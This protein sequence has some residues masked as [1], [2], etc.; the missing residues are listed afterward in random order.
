MKIKKI[1]DLSQQIHEQTQVYPGDPQ[2]DFQPIATIERDGYNLLQVC[3]GSQSGT[4]A[5]APY[6]FAKEGKTIEECDLSLFVGEGIIIP[7]LGKQPRE[8]ITLEEICPYLSQMTPGKIVVLHT[9]WSD[10]NGTDQYFSHPYLSVEAAQAMLDRGIRTFA[11]D[12][13]SIDDTGSNEYPVHHMIARDGG[14]I[15]ENLTNLA[16]IDFPQPFFSLL[17]I[18]LSG[19]DGAPMR[20]VAIQFA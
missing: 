8:P 20:A 1:V 14:V 6:H 3:M 2:P 16:A 15:I 12:T 17:P 9:G 18:K 5:D 10:Y 13:I 19:A 4:H 11:L 7:V